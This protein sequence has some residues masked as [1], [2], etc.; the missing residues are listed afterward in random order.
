MFA[1]IFTIWEDDDEQN[2]LISP[3][4]TSDPMG[5]SGKVQNGEQYEYGYTETHALDEKKT[6]QLVVEVSQRFAEATTDKLIWMIVDKLAGFEGEIEKKILG[7]KD[8]F[9]LDRKTDATKS[10]ADMMIYSVG[11]NLSRLHGIDLEIHW[12]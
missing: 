6:V 4:E 8:E 11:V 5:S 3:D 1:E 12:D 7:M 9:G 2:Q 10:R